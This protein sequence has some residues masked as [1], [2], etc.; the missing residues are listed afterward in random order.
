MFFITGVYKLET[1]FSSRCFGFYSNLNEAKEAIEKDVGSLHEGLYEFLVIEEI[2]PGI[3]PHVEKEFWF[4]WKDE[5]WI[6]SN[7][8]EELQG[9][10]N[11]SL[12]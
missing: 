3:F 6:S 7:K 10:I 8:P 4:E 9:T 2:H 12:G 5:K 1:L 11:F